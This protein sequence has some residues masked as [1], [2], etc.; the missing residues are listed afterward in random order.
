MYILQWVRGGNT[1]A[2]RI[3]EVIASRAGQVAFAKEQTRVG[4]TELAAL[5]VS[6]GQAVF[7][8]CYP[9]QHAQYTNKQPEHCDPSLK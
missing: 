7:D 6:A 9:G 8:A 2:D 3:V 1:F 4:D 5:T